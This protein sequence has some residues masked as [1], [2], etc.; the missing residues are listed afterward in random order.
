[1]TGT[2]LYKRTHKSVPVIFEPP[3]TLIFKPTLEASFSIVSRII[4]KTFYL[5]LKVIMLYQLPNCYDKSKT[6]PKK[7]N[8]M[9][10]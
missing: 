7:K 2:D 8:L 5:M 1:M 3:C 6:K 4:Y 9:Y 10:I